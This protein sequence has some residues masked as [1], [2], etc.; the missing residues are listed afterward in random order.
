[1]CQCN[2]NTECYKQTPASAQPILPKIN[3]LVS[4]HYDHRQK[5]LLIFSRIKGWY[6]REVVSI[7]SL[8]VDQI[9]ENPHKHNWLKESYAYSVCK[10]YYI[11]ATYSLNAHSGLISILI[12][13]FIAEFNR[14]TMN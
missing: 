10:I 6:D 12:D 11:A 13:Q 14:L 3:N 1:M 5:E 2:D 8:N 7:E 9:C 4:V